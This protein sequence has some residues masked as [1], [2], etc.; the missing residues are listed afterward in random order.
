MW[1]H[2]AHRIHL[3]GCPPSGNL[4]RVLDKAR[5]VAVLCSSWSLAS[6]NGAWAIVRKSQFV[7]VACVQHQ[8][9][10]ISPPDRRSGSLVPAARHHARAVLIGLTSLSLV[11]GVH[12]CFL[13][14]DR[15]RA[16][17][18]TLSTSPILQ[19]S[20]GQRLLAYFIA[21]NRTGHAMRCATL[22]SC[23]LFR[24]AVRS[25]TRRQ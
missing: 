2:A 18:L 5:T 4:S 19:D 21:G 12:F 6:S 1:I 15:H 10:H 22:P 20:S 13:S 25:L 3:S 24:D 9:I 14:R 8:T 11:R 23:I 16:L 7:F 17:L